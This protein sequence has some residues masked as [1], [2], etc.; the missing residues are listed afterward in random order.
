MFLSFMD[1]SDDQSYLGTSGLISC[2]NY[3]E[4]M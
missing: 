3:K 4:G 1:D 2:M